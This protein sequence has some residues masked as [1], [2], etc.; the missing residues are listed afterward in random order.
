[1]REENGENGNEIGKK[2]EE[3]KRI[4]ICRRVPI[5]YY[6]KEIIE[7][8]KYKVGI[9]YKNSI[10]IQESDDLP[11]VVCC[12]ILENGEQP[13]ICRVSVPKKFNAEKFFKKAWLPTIETAI[14]EGMLYPRLRKKTRVNSIYSISSKIVA[15]KRQHRAYLEKRDSRRLVPFP[16]MNFGGHYR[17]ESFSFVSSN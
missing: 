4:S 12:F 5:I 10:L 6:K 9:F 3:P 14:L 15:K 1:M 13:I 2:K 7:V 16:G 8:G 11:L 17:R